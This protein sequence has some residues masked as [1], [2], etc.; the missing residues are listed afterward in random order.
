MIKKSRA[1]P[2]ESCGTESRDLVAAM[3]KERERERGIKAIEETR[4]IPTQCVWREGERE[5]MLVHAVIKDQ[6]QIMGT[7]STCTPFLSLSLTLEQ[8]QI[9][10]GQ[11]AWTQ[12]DSHD[13][14]SG[15]RELS[16]SS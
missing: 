6:Q 1:N 10:V 15:E 5:S 12:R 9:G 16:L 11:C 2:R 7:R 13:D 4:H 3:A 8:R 14:D